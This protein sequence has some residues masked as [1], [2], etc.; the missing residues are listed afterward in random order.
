MMKWKERKEKRK[1]AD[2]QKAAP[3][4][5]RKKKIRRRILL[6][7]AAV[8][9]VFLV[10]SNMV[11]G[12]SPL[13]VATVTASK[14]EIEQSVSTSG[15]V[16][17][18]CT[19]S[20]FSQ[21]EAQIGSIPVEP[22]D[23]V[24]A[25]EVLLVYEKTAIEE[26]TKLA[27]LKQQAGE[28]SYQNSVQNNQEALGDLKEATVNLAVLEQQIADTEA[29]ITG[30]E[31]K[32]ANKKSELQHFGALLQISLLDWQDQPD[33]EEYMN[34]QKMVQLN[35]YEQNNNEEIK[36]WEAELDVYNKMLSDYKEYQSEMKSQKNS[37]EA[38]RMTAGASKELE[39]NSQSEAIEAQE[40]LSEL[41]AA[42]EGIKAE[43][44]GVVTE[45]EAVEGQ[46]AA[47]GTKLLTLESTDEV[48]VRIEVTKYDLDK[49]A[50][51]QKAVVTI[52]GKEY[53]GEVS[54]INKMA[55]Q[56]QSGA[57][58]VGAQI[59]LLDPDSEVVLGVEAKVVISTDKQTDTIVVPTGAVNVDI[60]GEFV[61]V[62]E[63]N[64]LVKKP[65]VTGISSDTMIQIREGL[66]EGEQV[67]TEVTAGVT[68]GMSVMAVPSV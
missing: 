18:D 58:V 57:A 25:G 67:V 50:L 35:N 68:E 43:F 6:G 28:G 7:I 24:K 26:K 8:L 31:N 13:P 60:N 20:Y 55:Q 2:G 16:A 45:V 30:L 63:N 47:K 39:A 44:D 21:V 64:T 51:G 59:R 37:A 56:N 48:S 27:Q 54:K 33:S 12:K 34:L 61:Y 42:A 40:N 9:V 11:Q 23:A 38:G 32:I 4:P 29:Y 1:A 66:T 5:G 65:V 17:A 3:E 10:V 53:Q 46:I 52:A 14:G 41:Q 19:K 49:I 15:T 62:V 22:G 36:G